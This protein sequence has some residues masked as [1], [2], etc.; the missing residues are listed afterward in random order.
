[1]PGLGHVCHPSSGEGRRAGYKF[2]VSLAYIGRDPISEKLR[3]VKPSCSL[4][5]NHGV[6]FSCV[7][8]LE[9]HYPESAGPSSPVLTQATALPQ[10]FI[11]G[12]AGNRR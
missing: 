12:N 3:K 8:A 4:I 1:V 11:E 2:Q 9:C 7:M 10:G 5:L 6:W